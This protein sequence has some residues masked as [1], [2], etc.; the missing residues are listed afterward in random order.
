VNRPEHGAERPPPPRAGPER[1]EPR[2]RRLPVPVFAAALALA[3][4]VLVV[5]AVTVTVPGSDTGTPPVRTAPPTVPPSTEPIPEAVAIAFSRPIPPDERPGDTQVVAV[6]SPGQVEAEGRKDWPE[7]AFSIWVECTDLLDRKQFDEAISRMNEVAARSTDRGVRAVTATCR[8]A[9]KVNNG[10]FAE[11]EPDLEE[12]RRE[13]DSLPPGAKRDVMITSDLAEMPSLINDD[14]RSLQAAAGSKSGAP[15]AKSE[16][17]V[18]TMS[19]SGTEKFAK[20][21]RELP[22]GSPER[23]LLL[24]RLGISVGIGMS[25]CS[26]RTNG[27]PTCQ[28]VAL[29]TTKPLPGG[30]QT[31][32][33]AAIATFGQQAALVNP[34]IPPNPPPGSTT[35]TTGTAAPTTTTAAGGVAPP[36]STTSPESSTTTVEQSTTTT[37]AAKTTTARNP[38]TT[39]TARTTTTT[40]ST[41]TR[42]ATTTR[43]TT[44]ATKKPATT[45]TSDGNGG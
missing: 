1:P 19:L 41:T 22:P 35:T 8:A 38:T 40:A 11:A 34:P 17:G 30:L 13:A 12:A 29:L 25:T 16:G 5:V 33:E 9:A 7:E 31:N 43:T 6:P 20:Y 10:D 32:V 45:T 44:T 27:S 3:T 39:T 26:G 18:A 28:Q 14:A 37:T 42:R 15:A 21:W 36:T 23:L 24:Q 4:I 2:G